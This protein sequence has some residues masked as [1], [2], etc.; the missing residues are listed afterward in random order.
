MQELENYF[1]DNEESKIETRK[2]INESN[3]LNDKL[4][5]EK[6]EIIKELDNKEKL[7][8][9]YESELNKINYEHKQ[10]VQEMIKELND[11]GISLHKLNKLNN[12]YEQ[13]VQ[14]MTKELNNKNISLNKYKEN[15]NKLDNE[16][17]KEIQELKKELKESKGYIDSDKK[18]KDKVIKKINELSKEQQKYIE[19]KQIIEQELANNKKIINDLNIKIKSLKDDHEL[20]K[21]FKKDSLPKYNEKLNR[22]K[23]LENK[24]QKIYIPNL[25]ELL[26]IERD[27]T[28]LK[29]ID[30]EKIKR[31]LKD[32]EFYKYE[33]NI[34]DSRIKYLDK[35]IKENPKML[36]KKIDIINQLKSLYTTRK[37][38]FKIKIYNSES[39]PPDLRSLDDQKRKLEDEFRKQKGSGT[40]T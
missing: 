32:G 3:I 28:K 16:Y 2:K 25:N 20:I 39:K 21:D 31:N 13:I 33:L 8:N 36:A 22:S 4:I 12:E 27:P 38:F 14:E 19:E 17:K 11:K 7:I 23:N 24:Y 9:E 5:E 26:N 6:E 18:D 37:D 34:S 15:I 1:N 35:I 40:F 10:K 29:K 30:N